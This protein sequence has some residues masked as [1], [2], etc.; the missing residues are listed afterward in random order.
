ML[1]KKKKKKKIT[2]S[3]PK[4]SNWLKKQYFFKKNLIVEYNNS[5]LQID[6]TETYRYL[7]MCEFIYLAAPFFNYAKI[8]IR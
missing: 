6:K 3:K 5:L 4:Q 2:T 8:P 7:C 1:S